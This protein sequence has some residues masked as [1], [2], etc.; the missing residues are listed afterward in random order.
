MR[1]FLKIV[2]LAAVAAS[3]MNSAAISATSHSVFI[4]YPAFRR[5][6]PPVDPRS[7]ATVDMIHD[8][9]VVNE[10]LINCGGGR[11]GILIESK[12]E[13]LFC[14]PDHHCALSLKT[15]VRRLCR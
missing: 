3:V 9:G 13:G 2:G 10:L 14:G 11:S 8:K 15:A 5:S 6:N 1:W 12:I 4:Y 7:H